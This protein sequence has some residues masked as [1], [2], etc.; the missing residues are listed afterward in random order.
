[1]T[2]FEK[3]AAGPEYSANDPEVSAAKQ[4][5]MALCHRLN[6]LSPEEKEER[7]KISRSLL[8]SAGKGLFLGPDFH[9]DC[10]FNIHVG[11]NF[12]ANYNV[13]ILDRAEVN[14]GDNVMI[15]PGVLISAVGHPLSPAK[16]R[17]RMSFAKPVTIGSDVWIGGNAVILPGVSIGN[18]VVIAAGAVVTRDIPDNCLAAGIPA[19]VVKE[20]EYDI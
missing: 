8:G 9:C 16:R 14:I 7:E 13:T 11:E 15:A 20:I 17:F 10:G 5:A 2:D 4:R 12:F 1:M 6:A 19:R 3:M 18:N